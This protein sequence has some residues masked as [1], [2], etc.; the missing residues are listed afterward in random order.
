MILDSI[1]APDFSQTP[2]HDMYRA[3]VYPDLHPGEPQPRLEN[4]P[5]DDLWAY[6]GINREGNYV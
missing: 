4:W 2:R 5:E 1:W 3:W 6:C